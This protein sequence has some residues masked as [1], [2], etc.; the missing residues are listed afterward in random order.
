M[1]NDFTRLDPKYHAPTDIGMSDTRYKILREPTVTSPASKRLELRH[2]DNLI[3]PYLAIG[4]LLSTGL[5]GVESKATHL[6]SSGKIPLSMGE[7]VAAFGS[8][9]NVRRMLGNDLTDYLIKTKSAEVANNER[10]N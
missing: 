5:D 10:S 4:T 3:N 7:A 8:A 6:P 2:S 1:C 9:E